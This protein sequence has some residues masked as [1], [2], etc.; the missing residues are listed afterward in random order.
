MH[1]NSLHLRGSKKGKPCTFCPREGNNEQGQD[2]VRSG[3]NGDLLALFLF[4][5]GMSALFKICFSPGA[6]QCLTNDSHSHTHKRVLV[7]AGTYILDGARGN[8]EEQ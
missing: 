6:L 3:G 7:C 1:A 2:I 4:S 8:H 5:A